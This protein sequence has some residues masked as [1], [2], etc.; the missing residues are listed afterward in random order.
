MQ[1]PWDRDYLPREE[2]EREQ[3]GK[4]RRL[5]AYVRERVP[6]YREAFERSGATEADVQTLG[7][8]AGLPFTVK[9]DLR[10]NYPFRLFAVPQDEI[11]RIHC[12]SGTTGRPIVAGYTRHDLD[13]WSEV[14]ARTLHQAGVTSGDICQVAWGYG[15]FTGGL[16][17]HYGAERLGATVVPISGGNTERQIALMQDFGTTVWMG[18]PSYATYLAEVAEQMGV[19]VRALPLR[20]AVLGAEPWTDRMRAEIE[21]RMGIR[22]YDIY[23]LTEVIGPGVSAECECQSGLHIFE[24]HFLPELID[25]ETLQP[26]SEGK[27]GELVLTTISKT[28]MPLIRFRTRDITRLHYGRCECGR[29]TVRMERVQGRSDDMLI[30]RGVNVFPSQIESI[31][32]GIEGVQP[33]YQI[34]VDRQGSMDDMEVQVEVEERFFS[35]RVRELEEFS[36]RVRARIESTL[37][38]RVHVRLM[39][40]GSIERS[41]GKAKRV[42]DRRRQQ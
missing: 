32:L 3:V 9:D 27:P 37:G 36:R 15:L 14:M 23:G 31:L 2:L 29:T 1:H 11:V 40:P 10:A 12:S 24:D 13:V 21:E 16:G 41:T 30:V 42:V 5:V 19:D 33:H 38:L 4:L 7:D 35:D 18:T 6:F 20:V 22:A 34:V 8:V 28:G 39:E 26:V 17:A 25:P